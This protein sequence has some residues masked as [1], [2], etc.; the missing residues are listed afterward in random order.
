MWLACVKILAVATLSRLGGTLTAGER[1]TRQERYD[2]T[3]G[4]TPICRKISL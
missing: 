4:Q 2:G 1:G 3:V